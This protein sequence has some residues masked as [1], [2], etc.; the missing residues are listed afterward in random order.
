LVR[1]ISGRVR[2]FVGPSMDDRM[3]V[4]VVDAGHDALPEFLL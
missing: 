2:K 4:D 1:I 3:S